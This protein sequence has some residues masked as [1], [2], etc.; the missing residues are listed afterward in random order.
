MIVASMVRAP[1]PLA[2]VLSEMVPEFAGSAIWIS[3]GVCALLLSTKD[4]HVG[5]FTGLI[6]G[7]TQCIGPVYRFRKL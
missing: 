3:A 2:Y 1:H 4:G 6:Q 5:K 7:L